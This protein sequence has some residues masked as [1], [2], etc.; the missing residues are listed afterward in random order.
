MAADKFSKSNKL[1][2]L[3]YLYI[4]ITFNE[5]TYECFKPS[6]IYDAIRTYLTASPSSSRA[7][8]LKAH[9]I[10]DNNSLV[11]SIDEN[12]EITKEFQGV[13]VWWTSCKHV[14]KSISFSYYL[15]FDDKKYYM[16]TF[17]KHHRDLITSMYLNHVVQKGKAIAVLKRKL[18][19]YTKNS[20]DD[21]IVTRV[22]NG[23]MSFLSIRH[24]CTL[25]Q[26][27]PKEIKC[28]LEEIDMTPADVSE[29]LMPNFVTKD[30]ETCLK[31]LIEALEELGVAQGVKILWVE[32]RG[33]GLE[34]IASNID[35]GHV[36][37]DE[38]VSLE[39]SDIQIGS[40][41]GR[42]STE[43]VGNRGATDARAD[44]VD[45]GGGVL[46]VEKEV[47]KCNGTVAGK[48]V[49]E[50]EVK[51][52]GLVAAALMMGA[53]DLHEFGR[54]HLARND[55]SMNGSAGMVNLAS[56]QICLTLTADSTFKEEDVS[57]YFSSRYENP[58]LAKE[59]VWI[60]DF[61]L[62]RNREA[63]PG[64]RKPSF[65]L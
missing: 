28:F 21:W 19:L 48:D 52:N 24:R 56:R 7:K 35:G 40:G 36:T 33:T 15:A 3:V 47:V 39:D 8:R 54:S 45:N 1:E 55:F 6:E 62:P 51:A 30:A 13:K 29:N 10:K 11:L 42:V 12:E 4:Q 53:D 59:N 20:S 50:N 41:I 49:K 60:Y 22:V 65:H 14:T 31:K 44:Y 43:E 9:D 57:N 63:Y 58:I 25:W 38:A 37:T 34:G 18:K 16:L 27:I 64:L 46:K 61:Y 5:Y 23:A 32:N 17:H 26:W 2:N